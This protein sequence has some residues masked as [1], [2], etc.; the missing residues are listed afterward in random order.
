LGKSKVGQPFQADSNVLVDDTAVT[1][2]WMRS[3]AQRT[4][5]W[6]ASGCWPLDPYCCQAGKPDLP[7]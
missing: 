6:L 4:E 3:R 1:G 5:Y 7:N 2:K